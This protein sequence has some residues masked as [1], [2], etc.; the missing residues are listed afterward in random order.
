MGLVAFHIGGTC[1]HGKAF[2]FP[3]GEQSKASVAIRC[4][5]LSMNADEK[6]YEKSLSLAHVMSRRKSSLVGVRP[7]TVGE[8]E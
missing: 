4:R 7:G 8:L 1:Q 2:G 5:S 3:I 6:G